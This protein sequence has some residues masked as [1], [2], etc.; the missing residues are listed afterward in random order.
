VKQANEDVTMDV[1][2]YTNLR[3]RLAETMDRVCESHTP[4]IV[5]RNQQRVVM[6]SL[7]DYESLDE[8]AYLL[9]SPKNAQRLRDSIARLEAGGGTVHELID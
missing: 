6:M 5:T 1:I 8:T 2:S 3:A 4:I 9:S 7:E